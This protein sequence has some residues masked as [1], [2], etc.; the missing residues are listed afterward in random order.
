MSSINKYIT[1]DF[2]GTYFYKSHVNKKLGSVCMKMLAH[3]I[4]CN[5]SSSDWNEVKI[6]LTKKKDRLQKII[7]KIKGFNRHLV[8]L[9]RF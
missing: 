6:S 1:S 4:S 7:S 2:Q 3:Y 8:A 5:H 9:K